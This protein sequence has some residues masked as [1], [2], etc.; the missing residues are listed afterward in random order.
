MGG[1]PHALPG[2]TSELAN[3][4]VQLIKHESKMV[5]DI[6]SVLDKFIQP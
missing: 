4:E 1:G 5:L 2:D 6:S 3:E